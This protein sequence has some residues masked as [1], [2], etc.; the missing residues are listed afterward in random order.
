MLIIRNNM[1]NIGGG[2]NEDG[3]IAWHHL[4]KQEG[5]CLV[6]SNLVI[7]P[8]YISEFGWY[9]IFVEWNSLEI[10]CWFL[11]RLQ[12]KHKDAQSAFKILLGEKES[13]Y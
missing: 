8:I 1:K 11:L 10:W 9:K 6:G 3:K 2:D 7:I 12:K 13:F 5:W 4:V